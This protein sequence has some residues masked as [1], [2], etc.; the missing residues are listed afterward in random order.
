MLIWRTRHSADVA[1]A[2]HGIGV[3]FAL[4]ARLAKS[5]LLFACACIVHFVTSASP[6]LDSAELVRITIRVR[7]TRG[8]EPRAFRSYDRAHIYEHH[9][10][11]VLVAN[12]NVS[13]HTYYA[14]IIA[15]DMHAPRSYKPMGLSSFVGAAVSSPAD[16]TRHLATQDRGPR[17]IFRL[18]PPY[19]S[20]LEIRVPLRT[21]PKCD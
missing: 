17:K 13:W 11:R 14:S 15:E 9:T 2:G 20:S 12:E 21:G 1:A 3:C 18:S 8:I 7:V 10:L 16:H 19:S 6:A 5:T 4:C